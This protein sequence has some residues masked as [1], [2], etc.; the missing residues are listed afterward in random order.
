MYL[1]HCLCHKWPL[2]SHKALSIHL[3]DSSLDS[4]VINSKIFCMD[5]HGFDGTGLGCFL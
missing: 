1:F 4:L 2:Y 3:F 5:P